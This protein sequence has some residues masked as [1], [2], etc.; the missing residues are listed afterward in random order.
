ML[1]IVGHVIVIEEI[2]NLVKTAIF[3]SKICLFAYKVKNDQPWK[4]EIWTQH[5][6][7]WKLHK[8]RVWGRL[9]T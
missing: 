4:A 5:G 7:T 9:V 6:C 2:K 1:G 3:V 8:Y